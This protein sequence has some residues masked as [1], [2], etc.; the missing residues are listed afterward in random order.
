MP[1][2][3]IEVAPRLLADELTANKLSIQQAGLQI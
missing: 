2:S 3:F 1:S